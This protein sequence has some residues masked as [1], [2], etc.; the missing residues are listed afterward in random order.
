[1]RSFS[2]V[3]RPRFRR[4][5]EAPIAKKL[6]ELRFAQAA[7]ERGAHQQ[8]ALTGFART[9]PEVAAAAAAAAA[10]NVTY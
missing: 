7:L 2:F 8:K 4:V 3:T 9:K 5:I 6:C 1:M 10:T